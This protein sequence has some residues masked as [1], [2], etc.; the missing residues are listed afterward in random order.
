MKFYILPIVALMLLFGLKAQAGVEDAKTLCIENVN[1]EVVT[2]PLIESPKM[3]F[4]GLYVIVQTSE[5]KILKFKELTKA[6]FTE[7]ETAVNAATASE[8]EIAAQ[9]NTINFSNFAPNTVIRVY[10]TSGMIAKQGYTD[11]EG[12]LQ[13]SVADLHRGTYIIKGGNTVF[14]YKK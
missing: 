3:T 6:Y 10:T 2:F 13:L 12:R 4:K 8:E 1:G 9:S 14:K 11:A 5:N 7:E